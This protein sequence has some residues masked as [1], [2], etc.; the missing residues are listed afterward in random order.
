VRVNSRS[1]FN[2]GNNMEFFAGM[3]F[4]FIIGYIAAKFKQSYERKKL[5]KAY[6]PPAGSGLDRPVN[7]GNKY[8]PD[9]D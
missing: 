5:R 7:P 8:R 2:Q 9:P 3:V 6:I 1:A 4:A